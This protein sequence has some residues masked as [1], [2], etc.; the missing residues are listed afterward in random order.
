MDSKQVD[1]I[2]NVFEQEDWKFEGGEVWRLN[3]F[4]DW[5]KVGSDCKGQIGLKVEGDKVVMVGL[6]EV[7][8]V[9]VASE[10]VEKPEVV[11]VI[12]I[13]EVKV[14]PD[15]KAKTSVKERKRA[16]YT[17]IRDKEIK[18]LREMLAEGKSINSMAAELK[19]PRL[20]VSYI[21]KQIRAGKK[22]KYE[23]S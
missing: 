15:Q 9:M 2:R 4:G 13:Q 8:K 19:A 16:I 18:K 1:F 20:A 7:K 12:K 3:M 6:G 5:A 14:K 10:S 23:K 17:A 21:V 11:K 22:L